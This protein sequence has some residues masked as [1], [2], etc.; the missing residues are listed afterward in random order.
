MY[1]YDAQ[2]KNVLS[3]FMRIFSNFKYMTG[4][5]HTGHK[6]LL[7]IPCKV[8]NVSRMASMIARKNSDNVALTAPFFAC[9]ISNIS[10]S[11]NRTQNPTHVSQLQ[12]NERDFDYETQSYKAG[13]GSKY[14]VERLM[15]VPY[16][17]TMQLD[18]W[19]TNEDMKLQ[20]L[21]QI[22]VLFNPAIDIQKNENP[23][24]WS[25]KLTVELESL[26]YSS[27]SVPV[28]N[29][30]AFEVTTLSFQIQ[31]FF[32]NPPAKVK[33][34]VVIQKFIQNIGSDDPN[35]ENGIVVWQPSDFYPT[36]TTYKN[37][38]LRVIGDELQ[39]VNIDEVITW[40]DIF[41]QLNIKFER[42]IFSI[43]LRPG[44]EITYTNADIIITINDIST[45]D[46]T[47][48]L[49]VLNKNTLP[50]TTLTPVNDFINPNA[51]FPD[52]GLDEQP[53]YRYVISN[54]IIPN[55]EAWGPLE[56]SAGSIIET[57]DGVNWF[58]AFNSE[59]EELGSVVRNLAD[60]QLYVQVTKDSW[61]NVYQG[62]YSPGFWS[63]VSITN[64]N[65]SS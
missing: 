17:I 49:G 15:P 21:E 54:N 5:N 50:D 7:S 27:R 22:L 56:A 36:I 60:D 53:G 9:S 6:E 39:L 40:H 25:Q 63:L 41:E 3:Q 45:S 52:N 28:G 29:D 65:I 34:Q 23:L 38:S 58:I 4:M 48:V 14:L 8:G 11:R 26:N 35:A 32:L 62:K 18:I 59:T 19:T 61:I 43:R 51:V 16:D 1:F 10:V 37:L 44:F 46:P 31:H 24:D 2:F 30:D 47:K 42:D 33:K 13:Q 64:D 20:I 12:V 55:T 57:T